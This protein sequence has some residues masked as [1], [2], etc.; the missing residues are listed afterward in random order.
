MTK[1]PKAPEDRDADR[2]KEVRMFL[3]CTLLSLP[4]GLLSALSSSQRVKTV[5]GEG[6]GCLP[7]G[8]LDLF[9]ESALI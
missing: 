6:L 9:A 7:S 1:L 3:C 8:G 4:G 5:H 2:T